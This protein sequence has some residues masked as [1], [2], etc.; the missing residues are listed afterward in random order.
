MN[1]IIKLIIELIIGI[2]ILS[3]IGILLICAY[4][5]FA[6]SV[7]GIYNKVTDLISYIKERIKP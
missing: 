2:V 3:S 1:N 6:V 5:V 4:E 7:V